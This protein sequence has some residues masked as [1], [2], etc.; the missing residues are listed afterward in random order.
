M[1]AKKKAPEP[2]AKM[3]APELKTEGKLQSTNDPSE[4]LQK[5]NDLKPPKQKSLKAL[6][7]AII[8]SFVLMGGPLIILLDRSRLSI[9]HIPILYLFVFA[10]WIILCILTFIGWRMEWGE[11]K[12]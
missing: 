10:L 11:K 6:W 1:K 4:P 2:K 5:N 8:A 7:T 12:E 3:S 9:A